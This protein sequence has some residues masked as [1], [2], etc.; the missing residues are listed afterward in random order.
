VTA[1]TTAAQAA[2]RIAYSSYDS[3]IEIMGEVVDAFDALLLK[4]GNDS[5]DTNYDNY[6][7]T[8]S[9]PMSY[10][11]IESLRPVFVEAMKGIGATLPIPYEYKVPPVVLSTLVLA[12]DKYFDLDR[13]AEIISRNTPLIKNPGFLPEGTNIS[14]L[15]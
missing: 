6:N 1:L 8:I 4:L 3:A 11:A 2:V 12:Y 5:E 15:E 10:N 9:D 14:I 7:I 13:E